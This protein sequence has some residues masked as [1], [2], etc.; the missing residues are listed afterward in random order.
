MPIFEFCKFVNSFFSL[1][2]SSSLLI[3]GIFN[4]LEC[5]KNILFVVYVVI[6]EL[7]HIFVRKIFVINGL[8][9]LV[10]IFLQDRLGLD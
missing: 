2:S 3:R 8:I 10:Q 1:L 6:F 9:K 4:A 7:L 5:I